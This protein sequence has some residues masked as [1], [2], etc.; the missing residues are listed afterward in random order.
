MKGDFVDKKPNRLIKEKSPYL[1]QHAYNP[2]D[3]YPW[4]EEAFSRARAED[5]PVFFSC[6]YSTCHWCHVMERESFE[7]A[8]VAKLLNDHFVAIKVDREERPDIDLIYMAACQRLTGSGGWPLTVIM[9]PACKPF[10]AGTYFPKHGK[11]GRMGLMDILTRLKHYWVNDR[12]KLI[13]ASESITTAIND[14]G[15]H[16]TAKELGQDTIDQAVAQLKADFD[17]VNGGFGDAPKFPMPHNLLFLL[18]YWQQ[19][20]DEAALAIVTKS[21][22][23]MR[24]GGIYDQLGFGFARYAVDAQWQIPHFEKM[25]YDNAL[26]CFVYLEAF[27]ITGDE[28]FKDT[29]EEILTYVAHEMTDSNGGFYSAQDADS[30]GVEGK[31]Y[32]WRRQEIL[33]VLGEREGTVFADFYG[34]SEDGNFEQDASVL[35]YRGRNLTDFAAQ[36]QLSLHDL[37]T[38][39]A[40]GRDKLRMVRQRRVP[41]FKDDKILTAWNALMIAAL[42]KAARVLANDQYLHRAQS[43]LEFIYQRMFDQSKRLLARYR[44]GEAA[45]KAFIDDYAFLLWALVEVYEAS[46]D[47]AYLAKAEALYSDVKQLF[48]D[49]TNGGYF[50]YGSDAEKLI[51]RPKEIYDGAIPSGNSVACWAVQRLGTLTQ[52]EAMLAIANRLLQSFAAA[53]NHY[54]AAHTFALLGLQCS[55]TQ[56]NKR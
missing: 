24:Q 46:T 31:Y 35:H 44:D 53:I 50:F 32:V 54:P 3:W 28:L 41:P 45:E 9:T 13:E 1:L 18:H 38:L 7:D 14:Q 51:S 30:E 27:A 16:L 48:W 22:T 2:V 5:K 43:A 40:T 15:H 36:H 26:L 20:G 56:R 47:A 49:D 4:S 55:L 39:L 23:A 19:T 11:W 12:E 10:F 17:M 8:E 42:A 37:Q 33:A 34:V 52:D 29:A 6:G 21:L 25:L